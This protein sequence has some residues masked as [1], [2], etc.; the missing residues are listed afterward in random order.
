MNFWASSVWGFITLLAALMLGLLIANIIKRRVPFIKKSLIP[1]SVLG[2]LLVLIF[3]ISYQAIS[4]TLGAE[5]T[6]FDT[7][8]FGGNG[9]QMLETI[10]YH[11]LA[12][13]FIASA[14]KTSKNK[15]TGKA[16]K[17]LEVESTKSITE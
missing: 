1:T 14:L 17:V 4:K 12:L 9:S 5:K 3:S 8:F 2:G 16:F 10:T 13:G 15:V 7:D 11:C 6:V